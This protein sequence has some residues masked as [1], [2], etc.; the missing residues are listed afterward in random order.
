MWTASQQ[1]NK[2]IIFFSVVYLSVSTLICHITNGEVC[3]GKSY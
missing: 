2:I 3:E 1:I